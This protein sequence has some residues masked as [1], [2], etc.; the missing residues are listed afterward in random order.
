MSPRRKTCVGQRGE[1]PRE[2][3]EEGTHFSAGALWPLTET[4]LQHGVCVVVPS[5]VFSFYEF[6]AHSVVYSPNEQ[7][8]QVSRCGSLPRHPCSMDRPKGGNR[9]TSRN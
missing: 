4:G 5:M 8:I 1:R 3:G 7:S 6:L 9:W 2:A